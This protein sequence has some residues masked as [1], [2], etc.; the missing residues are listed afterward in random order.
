MECK[1]SAQGKISCF[2]SNVG[3]LNLRRSR[4]IDDGGRPNPILLGIDFYS[5]APSDH[6]PLFNETMPKFS[7]HSQLTYCALSSLLSICQPLN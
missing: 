1:V 3:R 7:G 2:V 4:S 6:N 5:M